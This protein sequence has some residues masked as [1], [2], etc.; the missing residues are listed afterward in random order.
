MLVK[1]FAK[2]VLHCNHFLHMLVQ[3]TLLQYTTF[4]MCNPIGRL[5][6]RVEAGDNYFLMTKNWRYVALKTDVLQRIQHTESEQQAG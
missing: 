6:S 3:S 5:H 4:T 2:S 1:A